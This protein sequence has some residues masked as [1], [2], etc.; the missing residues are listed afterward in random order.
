[1]APDAA[2]ETIGQTLRAAREQQGLSLR[3]VANATKIST[4][5]LDALERNDM[6][7]LP[8]GIFS[9]SFVRAY[10]TRVGL[11]PER[12]VE[13]FVAEYPEDAVART[14]IDFSPG[15]EGEALER[16]RLLASRALK[17]GAVLVPLA[18]LALYLGMGG[19][20]EAA[21]PA[22]P[23]A[24]V[25][26]VAP[27]ANVVAPPVV[28]PPVEAAPA[29][30]AEPP[31]LAPASTAPAPASPQVAAPSGAATPAQ[32]PSATSAQA[33]AGAAAPLTVRLVFRERCWISVTVD[34]ERVVQRE[35]GAGDS[36]SF[37]AR[38]EVVLT[39]GNAGAVTLTLNGR[40]APQPLGKRGE[41]LTRRVTPDNLQTF[42]A[43]P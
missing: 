40:E 29:P 19:R 39:A 13:R 41:V 18:A 24:V 16:R 10:A 20:R 33:P 37:D 23:V 2:R 27:S 6:S 32:A 7:R 43:A 21:E 34:G 3:E 22:A 28:Q 11:E 14:E 8:G 4:V 36:R 26:P 17:A 30:A 42:L 12:M 1:M 31:A 25:A 5:A 15:G 35:F 38:R 9:R